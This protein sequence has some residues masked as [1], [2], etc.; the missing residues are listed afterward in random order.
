MKLSLFLPALLILSSTVFSQ[1]MPQDTIKEI[2]EV[3]D[4]VLVR[5]IRVNAQSPV[6]HSN[7]TQNELEKRN[8]G[9]DLPFMLN[10]LPSV[11]STSDAGAGV[12][13]TSFREKEVNLL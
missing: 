4:E 10:F 7:L 1:Q 3:L 9:Q 6:T 13:Y 8:L 12:G 11:V 2:P 5:A